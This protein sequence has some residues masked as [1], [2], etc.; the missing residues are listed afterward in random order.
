MKVKSALYVLLCRSHCRNVLFA[1]G[2]V[3]VTSLLN[4]IHAPSIWCDDPTVCEI[5]ISGI[6]ARYTVPGVPPVKAA[7][8]SSKE[9]LDVFAKGRGADTLPS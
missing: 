5:I 9:L 2:T 3:D 6:A 4:S 1:N 7:E 8:F